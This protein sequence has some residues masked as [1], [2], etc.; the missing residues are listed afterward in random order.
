MKGYNQF[1]I[2]SAGLIVGIFGL[3]RGW[4]FL[5]DS[6]SIQRTFAAD[7]P[8]SGVSGGFLPQKLF[9]DTTPPAWAAA[10][11]NSAFSASC[12]GNVT[13]PL[14]QM[15]TGIASTMMMGNRYSN[16]NPM[17]ASMTGGMCPMA[18]GVSITSTCTGSDTPPDTSSLSC[19]MVQYN[20]GIVEQMKM[21]L[22][23]A[24]CT[25]QCKKGKLDAVRREVDCMTNQAR[26]LEEQIRSLTNVYSQNIQRM[27]QDVARIESIEEDRDAQIRDVTERLQSDG[28][29][30]KGLLALQQET[31]AMIAQMPTDIQKVRTRYQTNVQAQRALDEQIQIRTMSLTMD[32][33]NSRPVDTYRCAP[34]GPPVSP[35]EYLTCRFEQNLTLGANGIVEQNSTARIQASAK[36]DALAGLLSQIA[37]DTSQSSKI[38]T[39]KEELEASMQ[40][41]LQV[42]SVTDIDHLYGS[43]LASYRIGNTN[44]QDFVMSIMKS[45]NQRATRETQLESSRANTTIGQAQLELKKNNQETTNSILDLFNSYSQQYA[46]NMAGLTGQNLPLDLSRC[47]NAPTQTQ[48]RC[49][50][51]VRTTMQGL[52]QG[53]TNNS[54]MNVQIKGNNP[55]TFINFSCR[56]INGCVTKLQNVTRNLKTEKNKLATFKKQYV[57]RANQSTEAFTKQIAQQ[58]SAQSQILSTRLQSLSTAMASLGQGAGIFVPAIKG[59]PFEYDQKTGLIKQPKN[60]MALVGQYVSP[61]IPDISGNNLASSMGGLASAENA[62]NMNY[63]KLSQSI[64]V[65]QNMAASCRMNLNRYQLDNL[66]QLASQMGDSNCYRH[67][68]CNSPASAQRTMSDL[69][70]ALSRI[71][72]TPGIPAQSLS[73]LQTGIMTFCDDPTVGMNATERTSALQM[74]APKSSCAAFKASLISASK[75]MNFG[76]GSPQFGAGALIGK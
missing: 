30:S 65:M 56:G 33:F 72:S 24:M 53:T 63:A 34:N 40:S 42:L 26:A 51:D 45:C 67:E 21:Q 54:T 46:M 69:Q 57:L 8:T 2:I 47:Q 19:E 64:V 35:K 74:N 43:K 58:L 10:Q 66:N 6:S 3:E 28:N 44:A 62:L 76:G 7:L 12:M 15:G 5:D 27:Q 36:K 13:A 25:V 4:E 49:L 29:G 23:L 20:A 16:V 75:T 1:L 38:P 59:E 73:S 22:E 52:L 32:C 61:P 39:S 14:Q 17:G 70:Q 71:Q 41:S 48:L 18:A 9:D 50:D 55:E 31:K 60:V 68:M 37:G 11:V